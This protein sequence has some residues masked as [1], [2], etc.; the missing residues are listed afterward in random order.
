MSKAQHIVPQH[1]VNEHVMVKY[2]ARLQVV[3]KVS[4]ACKGL[5]MWVRA[6]EVYGRTVKQV[7]PKRAQAEAAQ[8][9]LAKKEASL[10]ESRANLVTVL[11]K[12]DDLKVQSPA[13]C[14]K[15][16]LPTVLLY[17]RTA[18]YRG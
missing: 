18:S 5:C 2:V 9:L 1:V 11:A 13:S 14:S 15:F 17:C 12:V 4:V 3:E 10:A 8:Q 6:M 16:L 7:A